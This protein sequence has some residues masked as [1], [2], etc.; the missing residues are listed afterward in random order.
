MPE[1]SRPP[2]GTLT[3]EQERYI[4]RVEA[5]LEDFKAGRMTCDQLRSYLRRISA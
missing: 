2:Y 3:G 1:A 4:V 5:A